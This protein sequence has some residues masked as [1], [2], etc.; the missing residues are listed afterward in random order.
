MNLAVVCGQQIIS[1][2]AG[3]LFVFLFA[4]A[5]ET[6]QAQDYVPVPTS[7][8]GTTERPVTNG[9]D[10]PNGAGKPAPAIEQ[11]Q[12]GPVFD[13]AR[14]QSCERD[15]RKIG[16]RFER[17]P[18]ISGDG[19]CGATRPLLLKSLPLKVR[20]PDSVKVR[21]ELALAL[22]NWMIETVVPSAELHLGSKISA[23]DISTSYQCR[24]RNNGKI[25]KYSEHAF[26]NG[27]DVAGF[28]FDGRDR[29]AISVR[30]G[31]NGPDRAF[32]AAVRGAACAYFTT[33]IGP[34]TNSHHTDHLHLDLAERRNGYRL[35]Q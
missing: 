18:P 22:S 4:F 28:R 13:L 16:A 19:P 34:T 9:N 32:Q 3:V 11:Q 5:S 8:P 12:T 31:E 24:R 27:V 35:C 20:V 30:L 7:R 26:A 17:L 21:C 10:T 25:G 29:L 1:A 14:T 6:S 33:V 15:L 2:I 23:I